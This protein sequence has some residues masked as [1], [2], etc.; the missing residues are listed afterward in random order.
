MLNGRANWRH[1]VKERHGIDQAYAL[2]RKGCG[3]NE[4]PHVFWVIFKVCN[5]TDP[6]RDR[7]KQIPKSSL[8]LA[9]SSLLKSHLG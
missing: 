1:C 4:Y 6:F 2:Y 3:D 8:E 9:R 7:D 5:S